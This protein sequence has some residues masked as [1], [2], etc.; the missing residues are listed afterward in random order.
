M[1]PFGHIERLDR[2]VMLTGD[3]VNGL[4]DLGELLDGEPL[5]ALADEAIEPQY[6][7]NHPPRLQPG[8]MPL[9]GT[10]AYDGFDRLDLV[11]QTLTVGDGIQD[12]FQVRYRKVGDSLWNT[13]AEPVDSFDAMSPPR[14]M[15]SSTLLGLDWDSEYEYQVSHLRGNEVVETFADSFRTRLKQGDEQ[16]FSFAAYGDSANAGPKIVNFRAVQA[17]INRQ[18]LDFSVLLGDNVYTF[19]THGEADHRMKP[20]I[21][22]EAADW[23]ARKMD[24]FGIGNHDFF[25]ETGQTSRDLYAVPIPE[26][27]LNA[28]ASLPE[29]EFAEHS[30]SFDYGDTHFVTFDTNL[31]EFWLDRNNHDP[32]ERELRIN[33]LLDYVVA[34]LAASD[35]Q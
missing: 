23:T 5:A 6:V 27:G 3:L 15:H 33:R 20:A 25:V 17:Q 10:S 13:I 30:Y 21:S 11:W 26:A 28:Y 24:Y 7:V 34:D 31:V 12:S 22:P 14:V 1:R 29:G 18:D 16:A 2:R 4:L 19:G 8:D 35:A 32:N 9:D